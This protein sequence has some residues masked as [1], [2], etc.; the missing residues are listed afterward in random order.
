M[1]L[2]QLRTP[3][4]ISVV[5]GAGW[6]GPVGKAMAVGWFQESIDHHIVWIAVMDETG[7]CWEVEN[8]YIRFRQNF[9]WGR[10]RPETEK[11]LAARMAEAIAEHGLEED[12]IRAQMEAAEMEDKWEPQRCGPEKKY[13]SGY[14]CR[15][16][17]RIFCWPSAHQCGNGLSAAEVGAAA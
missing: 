11:D 1:N 15:D 12:T 17:D 5:G 13:I 4:P 6:E 8:P 10:S 7:Q 9:T 3:M 14:R 2:I 16:C